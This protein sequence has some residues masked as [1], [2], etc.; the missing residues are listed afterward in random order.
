MPGSTKS[1]PTTEAMPPAV[2]R[3]SAAEPDGEHAQDGQEQRG[4]DMARSACGSPS[5]TCW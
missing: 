3:T 2:L 5:V 1:T 4:A